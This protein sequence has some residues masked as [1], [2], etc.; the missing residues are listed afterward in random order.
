[1]L[2]LDTSLLVAAVTAEPATERVQQWL[3]DQPAGE[4]LISDWVSTEFSSALSIKLRTGQLDQ[5]E[6]NR[7]LET[8]NLL[9]DQSL[10]VVAVTRPDFLVAARL[11]DRHEIG[12]RAGDAI[13][14]AVALRLGAVLHTLDRQ[15]AETAGLVGVAS[16]LTVG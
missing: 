6:R 10:R 16:V 11:A 9:M 1:M 13:H 7:A 14:L 5:A 12:L 15:L 4:L 3:S 2:Y 8:F